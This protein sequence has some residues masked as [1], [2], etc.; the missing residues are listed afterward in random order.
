[1]PI[2]C[3]Q[4]PDLVL[5]LEVARFDEAAGG[6]TL[7]NELVL[8]R[9]VDEKIGPFLSA[10]HRAATEILGSLEILIDVIADARG[11]RLYPSIDLATS[12]YDTTRAGLGVD[13]PFSSFAT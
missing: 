3:E 9:N 1:L 7:K 6:P 4:R 5:A 12:R 2:Q 13:Q 11:N 8:D 10:C